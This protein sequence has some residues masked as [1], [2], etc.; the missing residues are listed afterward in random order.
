MKFVFLFVPQENLIKSYVISIFV[1]KIIDVAHLLYCQM[2]ADLFLLD[3]ERPRPVSTT[4][5][6]NSKEG[7]QGQV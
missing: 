5:T 1:L 7:Y 2:S 6:R 3:W 4:L